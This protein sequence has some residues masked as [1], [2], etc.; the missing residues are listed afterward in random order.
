MPVSKQVNIIKDRLF[1]AL[2]LPDSLEVRFKEQ[3]DLFIENFRVQNAAT[4][5]PERPQR[6]FRPYQDK[7]VDYLRSPEGL[8]PWFEAGL[9]T[10]PLI[11]EKSLAAYTA[12]NNYLRKYEL[13]E[14][15][16]I[17]K[18]DEVIAKRN[19][20]LT[21]LG[22]VREQARVA[23]QRARLLRRLARTSEGQQR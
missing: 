17:L 3:L 10:R 1:D 14:D 18:R 6:D 21:A 16:Q 11:R 20:Q 7:I 23:D 19:D 8:G 4:M 2:D 12:L 22:D 15:M 9:L 13:P 5:L